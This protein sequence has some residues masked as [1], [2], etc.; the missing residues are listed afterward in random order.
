MAS[1]EQGDLVA[2]SAIDTLD[3]LPSGLGGTVDREL[4]EAI[5]LLVQDICDRQ[6]LVRGEGR[7]AL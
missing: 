7:V 5:V 6:R 1:L 4:A 3:V 2:I